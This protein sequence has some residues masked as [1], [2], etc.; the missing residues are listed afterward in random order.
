MYTSNMFD[1]TQ[2]FVLLT[3]AFKN[4]LNTPAIVG[5]TLT[6]YDSSG[7]IIGGDKEIVPLFL[8]EGETLK[9]P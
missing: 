4:N 5:L 1:T 9:P 7:R 6:A 8:K 2:D 3:Q